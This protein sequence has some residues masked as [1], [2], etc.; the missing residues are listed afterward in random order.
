[1]V[2]MMFKIKDCPTNKG[3][4]IAWLNLH[5]WNLTCLTRL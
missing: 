2:V 1:M 4:S 5:F 3:T